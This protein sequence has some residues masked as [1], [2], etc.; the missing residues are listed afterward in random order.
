MKPTPIERV[1]FVSEKI[2][3]HIMIDEWQIHECMRFEQ[4]VNRGREH[5]ELIPRQYSIDH[6]VED[7]IERCKRD[8]FRELVGRNLINIRVDKESRWPNIVID[9]FLIVGKKKQNT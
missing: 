1:D 3:S 4:Y 5:K 6:L 7:N 8:I 2:E 9:G